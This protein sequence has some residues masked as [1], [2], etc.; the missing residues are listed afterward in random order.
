MNEKDLKCSFAFV[1]SSIGGTVCCKDRGKTLC[2]LSQEM[3][4]ILKTVI[5]SLVFPQGKG[6]TLNKK[7]ISL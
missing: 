3:P 5:C 2:Q 6:C 1:R 4:H 7:Q